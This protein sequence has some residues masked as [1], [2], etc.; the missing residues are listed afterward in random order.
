MLTFFTTN[1]WLLWLIVSLACLIIELSSG[2]F[3]FVCFAL[4]ALASVIFAACD[5]PFIAQ[6]LSWVIASVLCLVFVR[7]SLVKR[8]HDRQERKSNADALI[9]RSGKVIET[10]PADGYGYVQIDGDQWRSLSADHTE[11]AVGTTVT[12]VE[13]DSIILTVSKK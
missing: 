1:L 5:A 7:P 2:D 6:L 12:V 10:I 11:I 3:Y 8:L 4:G 13:R 9:G